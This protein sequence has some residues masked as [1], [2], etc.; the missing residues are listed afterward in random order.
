MSYR[1]GSASV[2]Q[3]GTPGAARMVNAMACHTDPVFPES[4]GQM[5][6]QPR[7]G[8]TK[9]PDRRTIRT[10]RGCSDGSGLGDCRPLRGFLTLHSCSSTWI[11]TG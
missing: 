6:S 2:S 4:D 10:A 8:E 11:T 7:G 1:S 3:S 5:L 9:E